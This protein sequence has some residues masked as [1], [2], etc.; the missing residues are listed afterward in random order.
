MRKGFYKNQDGN[1]AMLFCLCVVPI[2]MASLAA[3]DVLL[4]QRTIQSTGRMMEELAVGLDQRAQRYD[5]RKLYAEDRRVMYE[6][7]NF[8]NGYLRASLVQQKGI[9]KFKTDVKIRM[10]GKKMRVNPGVEIITHTYLLRYGDMN[11]LTVNKL[12]TKN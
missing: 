11:K 1:I 9:L 2:F 6:L 7:E 3:Y 5:K 12:D 4:Q 10:N 8:A